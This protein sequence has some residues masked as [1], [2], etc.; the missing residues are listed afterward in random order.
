MSSTACPPLFTFA[1]GHMTERCAP[2]HC[3]AIFARWSDYFRGVQQCSGVRIL[4]GPG[5]TRR[6][7]QISIYDVDYLAMA[8]EFVLDNPDLKPF[9]L[10]DV[11]L[12]GTK[13]G[14]GAYGRVDEVV[15][16]VDSQCT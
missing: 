2:M 5:G 4:F 3:C 12:T 7:V 15:I 8:E 11:Q 14:S 13:I 16:V 6:G 1:S 9:V 10:S